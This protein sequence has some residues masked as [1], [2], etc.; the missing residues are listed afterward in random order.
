MN[1]TVGRRIS[2]P[3]IRG[4][5]V[6]PVSTPKD[7]APGTLD[8]NFDSISPFGPEHRGG[9][10]FTVSPDGPAVFGPRAG[11]EFDRIFVDAREDSLDA[12]LHAH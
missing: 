8:L 11:G 7:S 12:E 1:R 4:C 9:V 5:S 10:A 2:I 6:A 3:R